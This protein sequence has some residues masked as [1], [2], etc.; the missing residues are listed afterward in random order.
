MQ[1][2]KKPLPGLR[3]KPPKQ[4]TILNHADRTLAPARPAGIPEKDA[5]QLAQ[6][7]GPQDKYSVGV[8]K[9]DHAV[10]PRQ[11]APW[12][13]LNQDVLRDFCIRTAKEDAKFTN[14]LFEVL[15]AYYRLGQPDE[16]IFVRYG[17]K[18]S[19]RFQ[20][21]TQLKNFRQWYVKKGNLEYRGIQ[22]QEQFDQEVEDAKHR[23]MAA[24]LRLGWEPHG[25]RRPLQP[26]RGKTK[27]A[28][29]QK[30]LK[31]F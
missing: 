14:L 16:D 20:N 22:T 28:R 2:V 18:V 21:V 31:K 30:Y 12:W 27:P 25:E 5:A 1:P 6:N 19:C 9:G 4:P 26:P 8:L 24:G 3:W 29:R 11:D 13:T 17:V 15:E 7:F 23:N 10:C